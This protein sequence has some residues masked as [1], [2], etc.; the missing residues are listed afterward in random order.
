MNANQPS[1]K[2]AMPELPSEAAV[3]CSAIVSR[4]RVYVKEMECKIRLKRR[5]QRDAQLMADQME[6]DKIDLDLEL[7]RFEKQMAA[8]AELTHPAAK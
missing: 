7:D 8:N 4:L 5:E 2:P 1:D 3:Q 6:A